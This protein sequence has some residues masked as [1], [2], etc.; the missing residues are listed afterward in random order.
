MAKLTHTPLPYMPFFTDEFLL[1]EPTVLMSNEHTGF[2]CRLLA[3][4]WRKGSIPSD[5]AMIAQMVGQP[6]PVVRRLWDTGVGACWM[7]NGEGRLVNARQEEIR[8][9]LAIARQRQIDG[10]RSGAAKRWRDRSPNG[11]AND[12]PNGVPISIP[13]GPLLSDLDGNKTK[14]KVKANPPLTPQGE[15]TAEERVS[16]PLS[17]PFGLA[18]WFI[19]EAIAAGLIQ[20]LRLD[21]RDSRARGELRVASD[22]LVHNGVPET[23]TRARRYL[24]AMNSGKLDRQ[25]PSLRG[26]RKA[27]EYP[28]VS[29]DLPANGARVVASPAPVNVERQ[30]S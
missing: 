7:R 4:S 24:A 25:T 11:V 23:Q 8:A 18:D 21:E 16:R 14:D 15:V 13:L 6:L 30:D 12:S 5:V 3:H 17:E 27:W 2:F 28:C 9:D 22:L 1:E 19:G 29:R 20:P 10:G 26:L